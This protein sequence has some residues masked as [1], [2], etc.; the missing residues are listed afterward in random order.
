MNF[1]FWHCSSVPEFLFLIFFSP[2][3]RGYG[4][5]F[6][7]CVNFMNVLSNKI[8]QMLT[9]CQILSLNLMGLL[10][11]CLCESCYHISP[12]YSWP[13]CWREHKV[14][15]L[16]SSLWRTQSSIHP[17]QVLDLWMDHLG[18]SRLAYSPAEC[19]SVTLVTAYWAKESCTEPC[20]K[21]W[22]QFFAP[23]I[24]NYNKWFRGTEFWNLLCKNGQPDSSFLLLAIE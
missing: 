3:A 18:P 8:W 13:Q 17:L 16:V 19:C 12:I 24:V 2:S 5:C 23:K 10:T 1:N 7:I 9:L 20:S 22:T 15:A 4:S 21:L 14:D 11:P 6:W